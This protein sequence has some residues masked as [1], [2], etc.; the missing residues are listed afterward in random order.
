MWQRG[1][2]WQAHIKGTLNNAQ[3]GSRPYRTCIEVVRSKS[4]KSLYSQ[5][6]RTNMATLDND[7]K[8]CYDRIVASLALII[9]HHFGVPEEICQTVGETL[10][11]MKFRLCKAMGDSAAYYCHQENTPIHGVG[12]GGTASLA[13]WLLVSSALFDCYQRKAKGMTMSNPTGS[14]NLRQWLEALVDDTSVFTNTPEFES[15]PHLVQHLEKD[16]QYWEHLLSVSGGCLELS[17]CFYYLLAG[18][19][20]PPVI[21]YQ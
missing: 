17:K 3:S 11:T 12:Q 10:R 18:H 16:A 5:L 1:V 21:R 15:L 8:S 4:Q 14:I 2:V 9:S 20:L 6:T 13:F 7:A 19:S